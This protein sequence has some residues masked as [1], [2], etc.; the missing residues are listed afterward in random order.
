MTNTYNEM[1]RGLRKQIA[2]QEEKVTG[3]EDMKM[4]LKIEIQQ[5]QKDKEE[6]IETKDAE[7]RKLKEQIDEISSDFAQMLKN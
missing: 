3:Q 4:K 7:I 2:Q 5:L 6:M 1:E